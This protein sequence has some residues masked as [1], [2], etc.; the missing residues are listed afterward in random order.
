MKI[1][2][3]QNEYFTKYREVFEAI[4]KHYPNDDI[5]VIFD[6]IR[7]NACRGAEYWMPE[8][9]DKEAIYADFRTIEERAKKEKEE[10]E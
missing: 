2:D 1:R 3:L 8:D 10:E 6:K 5:G 7:A 4:G 9:C